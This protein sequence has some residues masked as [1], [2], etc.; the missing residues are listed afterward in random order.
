MSDDNITRINLDESMIVQWIENN[1]DLL[2][3]N[4]QL[5][6][7]LHVSDQ[8][9]G[10]AVS[11]IERQVQV[12]RQQL[13]TMQERFDQMVSTARENEALQERLH[14]ISLVVARAAS[15][16]AALSTLSELLKKEF[17]IEHVCIEFAADHGAGKD[18]AEGWGLLHDRVSHGKSVCDDRLPGRALEVLFRE[19]ASEAA[20]C[21]VIPLPDD[22]GGVLGVIGLGS[23]DRSRFNHAM[24]TIYLDRLGEL[25]STG[26]QRLK[27]SARA[28]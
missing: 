25:I 18:S 28:A 26:L 27:A 11:L 14:S 22:S 7:T 21:A 23:T 9:S 24:G 20:S 6:A 4:P 15:F 10:G 16:E 8:N 13:D 17:E 2:E 12:L 5:L 3:R 19:N 1:P